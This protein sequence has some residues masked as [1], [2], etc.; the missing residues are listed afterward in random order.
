MKPET[1]AKKLAALLGLEEVFEKVVEAKNSV[2]KVVPVREDEIQNFREAQGFRY[3]LQAPAL[4]EA[5]VCRH[6]GEGFLVSR[7]NVAF[8]SWS[9]IKLDLAEQGVEWRKADDQ[10]SIVA[11]VN[12]VYDGN[13]P[14]WIRN[15]PQIRKVLEELFERTEA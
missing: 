1:R 11:M 10:E 13:E 15:I 3:F 2:N 4:F 7:K 14:I 5:K 6:C 8:C 9:C 12:R